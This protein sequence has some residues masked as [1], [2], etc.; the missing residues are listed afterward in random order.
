MI[1]PVQLSF[2]SSCLHEHVLYGWPVLCAGITIE[3]TFNQKKLNYSGRLVKR[4]GI[5]G[6]LVK[7]IGTFSL[8]W[9]IALLWQA[10][11]LLS[12]RSLQY[13]HYICLGFPA[14]GEWRMAESFS[15]QSHLVLFS[16]LDALVW[17]PCITVHNY[18][19][20]CLSFTLPLQSYLMQKAWAFAD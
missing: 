15:K 7:G 9:V 1:V 2:V 14:L 17:S 4:K 5:E 11:A 19:S 18:T 20:L 10:T 6:G 8:L 13:F 12:Y 16:P 3:R